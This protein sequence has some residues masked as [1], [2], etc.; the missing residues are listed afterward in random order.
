MACGTLPA[1]RAAF[2]HGAHGRRQNRSRAQLSCTF[3]TM[4]RLSS[5][6]RILQHRLQHRHTSMT[7]AG[8]SGHLT[9]RSQ[10]HGKHTVVEVSNCKTPGGARDS[11]D[12]RL[13]QHELAKL[14][15]DTSV[16]RTRTAICSTSVHARCSS[17]ARR[18]QLYV[19][20]ANA[21]CMHVL[22]G[23]GHILSPVSELFDSIFSFI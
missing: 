18:R 17:A 20:I 22:C 1:S 6:A 4:L 5:N 15:C 8:D 3:G 21:T 2:P 13:P 14:R 12:G 23:T 9:N 11:S 7:C 19:A 10:R 16:I